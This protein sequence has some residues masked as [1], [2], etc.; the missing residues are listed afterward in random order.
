MPSTDVL[1]QALTRD[2]LAFVAPALERHA[3]ETLSGNLWRRPGLAP[4]DRSLVTVAALIARNQNVELPTYLN[5]ALDSGLKPSEVSEVITHLAF[6]AGW[7][8]ATAAARAATDVFARR[9]IGADQLPTAH[10]E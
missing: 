8:N 9:G 6:Y 2:E 3:Q 4:R 5:L 1:P 10:P 7:G